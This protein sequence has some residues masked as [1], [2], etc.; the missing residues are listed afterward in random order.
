MIRKA[1][2]GAIAGAL[3][4]LG[5]GLAQAET[6]ATPSYT[7]NK[8]TVIAGAKLF[9]EHCSSCHAVGSLRYNRLAGDLGMTKAEIKKDIMLP[10]GSHYLE[11][12]EPAMTQADAAKW[13]GLPP[14]DLSHIVRA[15]GARFIYTYLTSFYW[16]PQRPSGWNNHVF[17]NVAM[18]NVLA[19]WGGTYA[20][21]GKE[22]KAGVEPKA[23][24][25]QQVADI[26]AF[27]RYA[28]DPSVFVRREIGG[29]VI[30]TL[31]VLSILA[32]FMKREYWKDVHDRE[33]AQKK[34]EGMGTGSS[35]PKS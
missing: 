27:L 16:D 4:S 24:Y 19:P 34:G 17:P 20:K 14:P 2:V 29:Y 3:V 30:G 1:W 22:L 7:F 10:G 33:E 8:P 31:V 15:T 35:K 12:M 32:Y 26:V 25:D 5:L 21:D 18:P 9:A 23:A 13:F 28:S 6:L 11:G